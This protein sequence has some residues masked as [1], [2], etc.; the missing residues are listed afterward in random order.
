MRSHPADSDKPGARAVSR[1]SLVA[2][3][4]A[5]QRGSED[6]RRR[7]IDQL[8]Q[9][10]MRG[11]EPPQPARE[12]ARLIAAARWVLNDRPDH[13]VIPVWAARAPLVLRQIDDKP[14]AASLAGFLFEYSIR[15]GDFAEAGRLVAEM[16]DRTASSWGARL[17]W[18]PS[19]ALYLWLTGRPDAALAALRPAFEDTTLAPQVRYALLEQ[20]AS[21]ALAAGDASRC[22]AYLDSAEELAPALSA[23]DLAHVCFLRA[24]AAA[25]SGD[26]AGA[27]EAMHRCTE[28]ARGVGARYFLAL[29]RLGAAV[30]RLT[31][32]Q[33]RRAERD[34]T[35]LLGDV[36]LMRARYLEWSVRLARASARLALD[37]RPAAEADLAAALRIA[38]ENGYVNCDPWG[39][40][41][42]LRSLLEFAIERDIEARPARAI[43]LHHAA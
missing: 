23:Q 6:E 15:I 28:H 14:L 34:L 19:A 11:Y 27:S 32:E 42:R 41:P 10:L 37:R 20:A 43:L 40:M 25:A 13:P 2:A 12:E 22:S 33:A 35:E 9:W 21:A 38:G 31:G 29:W 17:N 39:V 8:D 5:A 18:L 36:A 7:A 26:Y 30:V 4:E 24:G 16:W 1:A 3:L